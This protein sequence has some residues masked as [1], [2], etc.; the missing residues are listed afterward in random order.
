MGASVITHP[1]EPQAARRPALVVELAGPA[2]TGKTTLSAMLAQH[3]RDIRVAADIS[4]R[5][6]EHLAVFVRNSPRVLALLFP[7]RRDSRRFT[8]EEIKS[9]VYLKGWPQV[10]DRQIASNKGVILLDQGPVFRLATLH[11]F[12]PE[13]L[14]TP[15]ADELWSE[16]FRHWASALD[17]VIWLDAPN[18]VLESRINTRERWHA[19]KGKPAREV[20]QFIDHYRMSFVHVLGEL[21]AIGGP[22]VIRFDTSQAPIDEVMSALLADGTLGNGEN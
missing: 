7:P 2:G 15:A 12:G 3:G 11:A 10:L 21:S 5:R 6:P 14:R 18:P 8:W 4:V 17:L 13:M 9:V 1:A 22:P 20:S 19:V 16:M